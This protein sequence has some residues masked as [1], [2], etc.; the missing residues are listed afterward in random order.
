MDRQPGKQRRGGAPPMPPTAG[1]DMIESCREDAGGS[2]GR[3]K[4]DGVGDPSCYCTMDKE[5]PV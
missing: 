1:Y 2:D 4:S 3:E 5:W